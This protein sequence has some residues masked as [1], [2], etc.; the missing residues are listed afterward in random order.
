MLKCPSSTNQRSLA[1]SFRTSGVVIPKCPD[2]DRS[3]FCGVTEPGVQL[4][5]VLLLVTPLSHPS[6]LVQV[7]AMRKAYAEFCLHSKMLEAFAN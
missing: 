5:C 3:G 2:P 1:C 6:H 4:A 7:V